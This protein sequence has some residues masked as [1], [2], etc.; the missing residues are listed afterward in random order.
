MSENVQGDPRPSRARPR[1]GLS[2]AEGELL[3]RLARESVRAHVLGIEPRLPE[4]LPR[5]LLQPRPVFVTVESPP[6][7]LRGCIGSLEPTVGLAQ[8]VVRLAGEAA[9][10]DARFPPLGPSDL[11]DHRVKVSVLGDPRR[12]VAGSPEELLRRLRPGK[13]GLILELPP[14][15]TRSLF[16][17]EV[18]EKVDN[19]PETFL[20]QLCLKQGAPPDAWRR[21]FPQARFHVFETQ[22]FEA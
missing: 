22:V 17:P 21:L 1:P 10:R 11:A 4:G 19:D 2:P 13:E 8:E 7:R 12:I 15:G 16:L 20:Q 14:H 18:W 6:G 5:A 3:A 9:L